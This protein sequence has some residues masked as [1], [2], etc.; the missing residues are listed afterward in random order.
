MIVILMSR[1]VISPWLQVIEISYPSNFYK[2]RLI[3]EQDLHDN[4]DQFMIILT[5]RICAYK[6]TDIFF[7]HNCMNDL[8]DLIYSFPFYFSL[9][10]REEYHQNI[11]MSKTQL[12]IL[13]RNLPDMLLIINLL[14]IN[15]HNL[16]DNGREAL[17]Y[18][19]KLPTKKRL[20]RFQQ[21]LYYAMKTFG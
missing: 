20:I 1:T 7:L 11:E 15:A 9:E 16:D 13:K 12:D 10:K 2:C 21:C 6:R 18:M 8:C 4:T 19:D 5:K 3:A 14:R 17:D